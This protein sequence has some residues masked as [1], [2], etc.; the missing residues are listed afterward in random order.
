[1]TRSRSPFHR[2]TLSRL[3]LRV[4]LVTGFALAMAV[5]LLAAGAF[6]YWRVK[7]DLDTALD[8]DLSEQL[9]STTALV[10]EDG[11][12]AAGA[13]AGSIAAFQE[14]QTLSATGDVLSSGPG[15]GATSLLSAS[16][17][18]R[19]L[20]GPIH[21]QIGALLPASRRPLRLLAAPI[22]GH[23]AAAVLIVGVQRD[24][25]DEALRELLAQLGLAG[26]GALLL[27]A[28]IGE[29]LAK[30]ALAPVERYRAQAQTIAAGA[31]GVRLDVPNSRDDEV[32]R[33]GHT[34]NDVLGALER[35]VERERRFVNDA[36][37]ELRTPLTLLSARVQL[38]RR[39][40]RSVEEY[41]RALAELET[42]ITDL[43]QLSEQLLDVGLGAETRLRDID[44]PVD[45]H[46]VVRSMGLDALGA[47]VHG[48]SG[49]VFVL[50]PAPQIRQIVGNLVSNAR[51]HG[52]LPI[53]VR[54]RRD[55]SVAVLSVSDAGTGMS[56]E[57]LPMATERF[58]RSD[59]ARSRPGTGLGLA[60]VEVLVRRHGGEL[61]IC[62]DG[63]H[64][65][66][67]STFSFECEHPSA[68]TTV[69]VALPS[70]IPV[71]R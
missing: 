40:T 70:P 71:D 12:V 57:F 58:R 64:H 31:S 19:A 61:R 17:F 35:A 25:R 65:R 15:V 46:D 28:I 27:A 14:H 22:Q 3:P 63:V 8:R 69:T 39:R 2:A 5:L 51:A 50:M 62:S 37:H 7:I 1:M 11:R 16:Q 67:S 53:D 9:A 55:A 18:N 38:V 66:V 32:T 43:I 30:A 54:L 34:F 42:D 21:V 33:L 47:T 49:A 6:V 59:D 60:L 52:S 44:D 26:F 36:S 45:L 24:Q 48:E 41:E 29:R 23:G 4:R 56:P 13:D 20:R 10:G 68:G